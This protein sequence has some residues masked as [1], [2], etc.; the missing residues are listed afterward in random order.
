MSHKSLLIGF[1]TLASSLAIP[2]MHA[3]NP[4]DPAAAKRQAVVVAKEAVA[5]ARPEWKAETNRKPLVTETRDEYVVTY[6]LPKGSLGGAPVVHLKKE[7]LKVTKLY[8][9]Q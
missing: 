9:T 3:Q 5:A 8:H 6:P 1:F 7:N 4:A 2:S